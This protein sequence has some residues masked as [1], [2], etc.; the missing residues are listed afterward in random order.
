MTGHRF[1]GQLHH[2]GLN[3]GVLVPGDIVEELGGDQYIPV[4]GSANGVPFA[5]RLVPA[6][7]DL[8]LLY[9]DQ[10]VRSAAEIEVGASVDIELVI[11]LRDEVTLDDDIDAALSSIAAG[12]GVWDDYS[13]AKRASIVKWINEAKRPRTRAKR[14]Q[15]LT[16]EIRQDL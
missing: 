5:N 6:G 3:Y 10:T 9:L 8:R 11:D 15:R 13:A 2:V 4:L 14:I 16:E 12:W 1:I 7:G